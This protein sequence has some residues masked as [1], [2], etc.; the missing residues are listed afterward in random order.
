VRRLSDEAWDGAMVAGRVLVVACIIG[1]LAFCTGGCGMSATDVGR[2]TL[3]KTATVS[4]VID[5][6][7]AEARLE[8]SA[9]IRARADATLEEHQ[10]AMAPFDESLE[11]SRDLYNAHLAAE[12]A[13]DAY[14]HGTR[15]SWRETIPCV[16]EAL[17]KTVE[18]ATRHIDLPP[19]VG[20][21]TLALASIAEGTCEQPED[22]SDD[23]EPEQ[24]Q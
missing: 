10:A 1:A 5:R 24:P 7:M 17:S 19:E 16:L 2:H 12:H 11:A 14:E 3:E 15:G 9:R 4:A 23:N 20:E 18:I 13:I 8:T 22:E 6:A 21:L